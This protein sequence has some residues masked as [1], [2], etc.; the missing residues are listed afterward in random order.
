MNI[1]GSSIRLLLI[2]IGDILIVPFSY[3]A[4]NG[5]KETDLIRAPEAIK[6][7]LQNFKLT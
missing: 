4:L 1:K 3:A 2:L 5:L 6:N 7:D